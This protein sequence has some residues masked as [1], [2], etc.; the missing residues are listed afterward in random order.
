MNSPPDLVELCWNSSQLHELDLKNNNLNGL[1][2]NIRSLKAQGKFDFIKN[3]L[4]TLS[5][6]D[7]ICLVE[8]WLDE[9]DSKYF[10]I[11]NYKPYHFTRS[12][13]GGGTVCFIKSTIQCLNCQFDSSGNIQITILKCKSNSMYFNSILVCNPTMYTI[14][15]CTDLLGKYLDQIGN[16]RTIILGD[17]NIDIS[18]AS[19]QSDQYMNNLATRGYHV[20]NSNITRPASGSVIDH[21]I[22]NCQNISGNIYT[23]TNPGDIT[24]HNALLWSLKLKGNKN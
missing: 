22:T 8:T 13:R 23:I 12:P 19:I 18:K 2:L 15:D 7:V 5:C 17:F 21:L 4:D 1:F 9:A 3:N 24:D 10:S 6:V 14:V 20:L 16:N 11:P